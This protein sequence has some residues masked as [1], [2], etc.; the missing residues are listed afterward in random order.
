MSVFFCLVSIRTLIMSFHI[1]P[2]GDILYICRARACNKQ[3]MG[4]VTYVASAS[5]GIDCRVDYGACS[6]TTFS[7]KT[8]LVVVVVMCHLAASGL[9]RSYE[10]L[11]SKWAC[12]QQ[13][14]FSSSKPKPVVS[15]GESIHLICGPP[16]LLLPFTFPAIILSSA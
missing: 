8:R 14:W 15:F 10:W 3:K 16:L 5:M 6:Y 13:P 4:K 7:P 9:W 2:K 12:P 1:S 11:T